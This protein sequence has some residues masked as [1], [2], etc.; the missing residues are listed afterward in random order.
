MA[1][2]CECLFAGWCNRWQRTQQERD[3]HFCA[4]VGPAHLPPVSAT[5]QA[6]YHIQW[7][8]ERANRLTGIVIPKPPPDGA[9][10]FYGPTRP[11]RK[12]GGP[13]TELAALLKELSIDFMTGCNCSEEKARMDELGVEGVREHRQEFVRLLWTQ[14]R[15]R[16]WREWRKAHQKARE[17]QLTISIWHPFGWLVDEAC[18]RAEAKSATVS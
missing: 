4:G 15:K 7:Q 13:G 14:A 18:R 1:E 8:Q 3:L 17:L 16:N 5:Q 6:H 2:P 12:P 11:P 9:P 10:Q